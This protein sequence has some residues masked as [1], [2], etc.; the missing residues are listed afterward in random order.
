MGRAGPRPGEQI[1]AAWLVLAA[2]GSY[3]IAYRFYAGSSRRR[4]CG[5]RHPRH[6]GRT[7]RQRPRL[8]A[9]GPLGRLRPPL[10][11]DRRRRARWSAPSLA[12]QFGYLPGTLWIM[13]GV[14]LGGACRTS[15]SCSSRCGATAR[16]LG[17]MARDEIGPIGGAAALIGVLAIMIILLAV[18]GARRRQ[19]D[20]A[21]PVGHFTVA[22]TIPIA[23]L[24]GLY[25][26]VLR[27][28]RVLEAHRDRRRAA[29]A[30]DRRSAAWV[31]GPDAAPLVHARR[32][33]TLAFCLIV[34]GF[35]AAVLPVWL[36]LAPRDYL[37]T[38]MK[39]GTIVLL[40]IG[41]LVMLPALQ[42]PA[43]TQF[44]R[45]HGPD[46][47]R[48]AVPVRVHHDRLRR[49]LGLPR[50][51]RLRHDAEAD[52]E[53]DAMRASSATARCCWSR[54]SRSWR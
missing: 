8:R 16:S 44:A 28:G 45:R 13:V 24:M 43:V 18:L 37:S 3:A 34:Y 19:R 30:R 46:L 11:G 14:V 1:S 31:A 54:S 33:E 25:M 53:R 38:F 5:R 20:A 22:V 50:A 47:R 36:L 4:S 6:A 49:D 41:I 32:P 40:A 29:A 52:R 15:S 23:I 39:I 10:R 9:D 12:A 48:Q 17:Q 51:D 27:P 35:V 2:V 42:M 26:R 21:S 7:A